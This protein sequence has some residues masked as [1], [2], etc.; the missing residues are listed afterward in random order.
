MQKYQR[1]I[2]VMLT[3]SVWLSQT[4]Q[5]HAMD[6]TVSQPVT[7][8]AQASIA[9]PQEAPYWAMFGG[10]AQGTGTIDAKVAQ[11]P[12]NLQKKGEI[13]D[14]QYFEPLVVG[15]AIYTI[16]ECRYLVKYD[17]SGKE[18]QRAD[19]GVTLSTFNPVRMA[20]G[21]HKIYVPLGSYIQ[22]FDA[23][24][25]TPV[26][27]SKKIASA[28]GNSYSLISGIT[29]Y[30][31]YIYSGA[32]NAYW[33][34]ATDGMFVALNT[35]DQDLN[36]NEEKEYAWT[37]YEDA[38]EGHGFYWSEAAITENSIIFADD[39]GTLVSH[40]LT[41]DLVF[42]TWDL[43][44]GD[45]ALSN[46]RSN[47]VYME[48]QSAI[49]LATQGSGQLYRIVLN[50]DG[51]FQRDTLIK[52]TMEGIDKEFQG[53]S[54]GMAYY[55]GRLYASSGGMSGTGLRVLDA[56]TL[57]E[58]YNTGINTQSYP[59]IS[60]AYATKENGY[61]VIVYVIDFNGGL[62]AFTDAAG[63]MKADVKKVTDG[64][65]AY[66]SNSVIGDIQGNLYV[67]N[68]Y[69][70]TG[71]NRITI[72]ENGEGSDTAV[73]LDHAIQRIP[74]VLSYQDQQQVFYT[75]LRYDA[76]SVQEKANVT[77][78]STLIRKEQEMKEI[79]QATINSIIKKVD[80]IP[81]R[82]TLEDRF[83]L[84][85]IWY[86]YGQL[87]DADREQVTNVH[88]LNQALNEVYA[89]SVSVTSL[90]E[91]IDALDLA[92]I[93]AADLND[94][95][96]LQAV[97]DRLSTADQAKV[98]NY[99]A[100]QKAINIA[101]LSYDH[102]LVPALIQDISVLP[103]A[104]QIF[105]K[106]E[107]RINALMTR[108]HALMKEAQDA[109]TNAQKLIYLQEILTQQRAAVDALNQDIW[110]QLDPR[111]ITLKDEGKVENFCQRYAQLPIQNQAYI[112]YYE[113]VV[114]AQKIIA[115]LQKGIIPAI[116]FEQIQ[117]S[118]VT[119]RYDGMWN[120]I[121]YSMEINGLDITT[122]MDMD[123]TLYAEETLSQQYPGAQ[124]LRTGQA[125]AYP[126]TITLTLK[127]L[128]TEGT[129]DY[130]ILQDE[131]LIPAGTLTVQDGSATMRLQQGGTYV[132]NYS[133]R[134][135]KYP[136]ASAQTY[137][138]THADTDLFFFIASMILLIYCVYCR[139]RK[140]GSVR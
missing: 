88:Q 45:T 138:A 29:Y 47:I 46:V 21:D 76:L 64:Y 56:T 87:S 136:F 78:A 124:I 3:I 36:Q 71:G 51:T 129:Y 67:Y 65:Y 123:A 101:Q 92:A 52:R 100:L 41:Q 16:S 57:Q 82:I 42:D 75:K 25:L 90:I 22:A 89:L 23:T 113:D 60:T 93:T 119:Y 15:N 20:Y 31:G 116:V 127:N 44:S 99:A 134:S 62:V 115:S 34:G 112:R 86:D 131:A 10:N 43:Q 30:N 80:E 114:Q 28:A 135:E 27:H 102:T 122:V 63:Q 68:G 110:E 109:V 1:I 55:H 126:G 61:R 97:Y 98:S 85:S 38:P 117:G 108:Y 58:I 77:E 37:M 32:T 49:A 9:L 111:N 33:S 40:H 121:S 132:L 79:V 18:L 39:S 128:A 95:K 53:V 66:N 91:Q 96:Q 104:D 137:D 59:L 69:N 103:E 74:E 35:K 54:G 19:L 107:A 48:D 26:W 14:E 118:D 72:Y 94:L 125:G 8:S 130:Y 105:L 13:L 4:A 50:E 7:K 2:A 73:D 84:E 17:A 5:I 133:I 11:D 70:S 140:T 24:T 81:E 12:A 106:D 6:Q 139:S 83:A 120:D